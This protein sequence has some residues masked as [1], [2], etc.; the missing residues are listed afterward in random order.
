[1]LVTLLGISF[2][3]KYNET[4]SPASEMLLHEPKLNLCQ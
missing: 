4:I 1:M 3:L 2:A